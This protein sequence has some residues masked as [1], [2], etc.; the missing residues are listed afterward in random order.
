MSDSVSVPDPGLPKDNITQIAHYFL[1]ESGVTML[2]WGPG[3]ASE[4]FAAL[5]AVA[6]VF[7]TSRALSAGAGS[8]AGRDDSAWF[9]YEGTGGSVIT[10]HSFSDSDVNFMVDNVSMK[11]GQ[12]AA[13]WSWGVGTAGAQV[14]AEAARVI[15]T[16]SVIPV[17]Q[18][19]GL[20]HTRPQSEVE[21]PVFPADLRDT[22]ISTGWT[23]E[24]EDLLK[25]VLNVPGGR[26]QVLFL[27]P[28]GA[29]DLGLMSPVAPA[30]NNRLPERLVGHDFGQYELDVAADMAM[31]IET[32][33]LEPTPAFETINAHARVLADYADSIEAWLGG[34]DDTY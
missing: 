27:M 3:T 8:F 29:S 30:F 28:W 34:T 2:A 21:A 12:I 16:A 6:P 4:L 1:T 25:A 7:A 26:S 19:A 32:F 11:F 24:G 15:A 18:I 14:P 9:A 5:S 23:R 31:L 20:E 10:H 22:L 17:W 33:P 13:P